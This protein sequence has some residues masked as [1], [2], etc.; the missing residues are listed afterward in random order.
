MVADIDLWTE[1]GVFSEYVKYLK[2]FFHH[3]WRIGKDSGQRDIFKIQFTVSRLVCIR[4]K[5]TTNILEITLKFFFLSNKISNKLSINLW[6]L[7]LDAM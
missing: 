6:R 3:H 2:V 4:E 1:K 7:I 5:S